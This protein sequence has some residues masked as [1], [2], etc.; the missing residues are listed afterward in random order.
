MKLIKK[1]FKII[2]IGLILIGMMICFSEISKAKV[3]YSNYNFKEHVNTQVKTLDAGAY[4]MSK[5]VAGVYNVY[6]P[7]S[8]KFNK[9]I[10]QEQTTFHNFLVNQGDYIV[11]NQPIK[12]QFS[13]SF[14]A[15]FPKDN[16]GT[17]KVKEDGNL[18]IALT[19]IAKGNIKLNDQIFLLDNQQ[20]EILLPV[21][22]NDII[23]LYISSSKGTISNNQALEVKYEK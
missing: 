2:F 4:K 6:F 10:V 23:T 22:K 12:Y 1:N 13:D 9:E 17:F 18:K 14:T 3:D 11:I 16:V 5:K 15:D 21:K 19:G 7:K 8:T 20:P